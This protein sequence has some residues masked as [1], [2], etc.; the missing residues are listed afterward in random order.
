M[1]TRHINRLSRLRRALIGGVVLVLLWQVELPALA[2]VQF[3][4]EIAIAVNRTD[5][6]TLAPEGEESGE[7]VYEIAPSF[8]FEQESPRF[9]TSVQYG[10]EAFRYSGLHESDVFHQLESSFRS[11][12]DPDNFFIDMG[13]SRDQVVSS[14]TA[15]ISTSNL[16]ITPNRVDRDEAYI[17][18]GLEYAIGDNVSVES[19]YR[20][21]RVQYDNDATAP[22]QFISEFDFDS[23]GFTIDN[24]AK[25]QG[26]GWAIR[27]VGER[28]E[29]EQ[30]PPWEYRQASAEVGAWFGPRVR[31]FVS[32]GKESAWDQPLDPALRDKFWEAGVE[33]VSSDS[34]RIE[35]AA[36]DR[37]FGSS[38]RGRVEWNFR[39][40]TML[41]SYTEQPTTA[42]R[43]AYDRNQ[44]LIPEE[45]VDYL[46]TPGIAERYLSN[47]FYWS[48]ALELRRTTVNLVAYDDRREDRVLLDGTPAEDER[49]RGVSVGASWR[50]GSKTIFG[51]DGQRVKRKFEGVD[52]GVFSAVSVSGEYQLGSRTVLRGSLARSKESF[53]GDNPEARDYSANLISLRLIRSF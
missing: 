4:G 31:G 52:E 10:A 38:K 40:G 13:L 8:D 15:P 25:G 42:G 1:H 53:K 21:T 45:P 17:G 41:L 2:D 18:P 28:T 7:T 33:V 6:L 34:L 32:G 22:S 12:L 29:Y 19:A 37:S 44:V 26:F 14:L 46:T 5:N 3:E 50:A 27:Y 23:I 16:P 9:T 39:R 11:E 36:G 20:K 47:E 51:L 43:D 48:T 24:Y 49:Q 35:L 30:L